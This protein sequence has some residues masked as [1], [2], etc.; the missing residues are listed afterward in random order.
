MNRL[1]W[2]K[3]NNPLDSIIWTLA[4]GGVM[5]GIALVALAIRASV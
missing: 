3:S 4:A 5:L 2:P 1:W